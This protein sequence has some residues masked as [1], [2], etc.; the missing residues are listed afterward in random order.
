MRGH[1]KTINFCI[2]ENNKLIFISD[3]DGNTGAH[4]LAINKF[5]DIL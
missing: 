4:L 5:Y 1:E 2:N 3:F